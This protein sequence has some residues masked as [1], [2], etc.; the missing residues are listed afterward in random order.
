MGS[1]HGCCGEVGG[2]K[3][4]KIRKDSKGEGGRIGFTGDL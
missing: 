3:T 4:A 1:G 2:L